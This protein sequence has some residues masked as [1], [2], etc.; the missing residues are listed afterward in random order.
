MLHILVKF[1]RALSSEAS[2]WQIAIAVTLGMIMGIT[3]LFRLH[4]LLILFVVLFFRVNIGSFLAS[5]I[6]FSG[7]AWLFDPWLDQLGGAVLSAGGLQGLWTALFNTGLGRL[8]Q[9]N[10]TLTMGGLLAGLI[11][12]PIVLF[13]TRYL[14]IQ[15][16]ARVMER[17]NRL[18][19]VRALRASRLAHLY[20][21]GRA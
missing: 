19:I 2:P 11:L 4:N 9:F 3:P 8:S 14:V 1:L 6:L 17:V 5:F 21:Y 18:H 15:Y 13:G 20:S 7:I 12:A 16:R 10:H